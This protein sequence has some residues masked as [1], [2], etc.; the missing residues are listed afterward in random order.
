MVDTQLTQYVAIAISQ[1]IPHSIGD[2]AAP[3][4][5]NIHTFGYLKLTS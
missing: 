2:D 5:I 3:T 1:H 4:T